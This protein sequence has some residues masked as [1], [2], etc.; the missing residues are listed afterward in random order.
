MDAE[1][2]EQILKMLIRDEGIRQYPYIDTVGKITIGIGYNL[3]DRGL[4][5]E[6]IDNQIK[7]DINYFYTYLT[8]KYSFFKNLSSPRKAA[9]VDMAF[10]GVKKIEE[11]KRMWTALEKEDYKT[12]SQEVINSLYAKQ[13]GTRALRIAD[14]IL[15]G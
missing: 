8:T 11:F 1:L 9:L 14:D 5:Q 10:M 3:T 13:V 12:A 15:N 6:W 4:P 2:Y 7:E